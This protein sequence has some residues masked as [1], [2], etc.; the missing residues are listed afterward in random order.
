MLPSCIRRLEYILGDE[1]GGVDVLG[2]RRRVLVHCRM[3]MS[4][5]GGVVVA[6]GEFSVPWGGGL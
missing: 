1:D 5:S 3:G 6:Y 4:R 2:R